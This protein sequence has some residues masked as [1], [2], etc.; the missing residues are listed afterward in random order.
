MGCEPQVVSP[1]MSGFPYAPSQPVQEAIS[2]P[3]QP[4]WP[5][6]T[7]PQSPAAYPRLPTPDLA[8]YARPPECFSPPPGPA[9]CPLFWLQPTPRWFFNPQ[10]GSCSQFEY[11]CGQGFNNFATFSTCR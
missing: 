8:A 9:A 11:K 5:E 2:Y 7:Y 6:A 3:G 1:Y 10:T 4:S